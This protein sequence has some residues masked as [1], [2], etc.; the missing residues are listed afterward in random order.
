MIV[1]SQKI[2]LTQGNCQI[3]LHKDGYGIAAFATHKWVYQYKSLTM[4]WTLLLK[5]S[6]NRN[7]IKPMHK[8]T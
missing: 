5:V 1:T 7:S 3:E 6:K 2:D 8:S 4:V